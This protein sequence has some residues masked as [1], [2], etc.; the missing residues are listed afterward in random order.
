MS[1]EELVSKKIGEMLAEEKVES[2]VR[3]ELEERIGK[4][5]WQLEDYLR[6]TLVKQAFEKFCEKRVEEVVKE[7]LKPENVEETIR[8]IL[9]SMWLERTVE[10]KVREA[11]SQINREVFRDEVV[12]AALNAAREYAK[13][14]TAEELRRI[15]EERLNTSFS[16][17]MSSLEMLRKVTADLM[18]RVGRLEGKVL[19]P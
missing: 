5:L 8:K 17:I 3:H 4:V 16:F 11:F 9:G 15:F 13:Q 10:E 6:D 18:E 2:I 19:K 12:K 14:I 7:R 1:L